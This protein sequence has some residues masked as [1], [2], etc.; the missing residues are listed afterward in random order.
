MDKLEP[1]EPHTG[2]DPAQG[3]EDAACS[4][5]LTNLVVIVMST[6]AAVVC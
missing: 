6:I 3:L 4:A 2:L 1:L 5:A